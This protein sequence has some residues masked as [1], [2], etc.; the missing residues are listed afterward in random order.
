MLFYGTT[1]PVNRPIFRLMAWYMLHSNID[2]D[3]ANGRIF[4]LFVEVNPIFG[5]LLL[6]FKG[7]VWKCRISVVKSQLKSSV[8]TALVRDLL[9]RVE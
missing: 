8:A 3:A 4:S 7:K 2:C 6:H 9:C 1:L 5:V